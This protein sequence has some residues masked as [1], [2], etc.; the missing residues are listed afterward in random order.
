V[1]ISVSSFFYSDKAV[2]SAGFVTQ[3]EVQDTK[4]FSLHRSTA[5]MTRI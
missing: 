4:H 5:N 3:W 1:E 2:I